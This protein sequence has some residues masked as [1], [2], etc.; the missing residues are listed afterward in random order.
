[1]KFNSERGGFLAF[2]LFLFALFV[3]AVVGAALGFVI[4]FSR[5]LPD[6]NTINEYRPSQTTK[7]FSSDGQ[8]LASLF[9]ENREVVPISKIPTELKLAIMAVEDARFYEHHG[10]D[11]H[12]VMR[13]L[14]RNFKEKRVVEGAS[15]ITQQLARNLFLTRR[16]TL[17]RKLQE[18]M[19]AL[20][21]ER[22]YSKEEI[23]ELYLN[24]IYFGEGAYGVQIAAKTYFGKNPS[25]L[26]LA[27]SALLAGLPRSPIAYS[28]YANFKLARARQ[29]QVLNRMAEAGFIT[30]AEAEKARQETIKL[31]PSRAAQAYRAPYFV[32]YVLHVLEEEFG[33]DLVYRGGLRVHTTVDMRLQAMAD[34]ILKDSVERG[35]RYY[36]ISQGALVSVEPQTGY[37]RAMVGGVDFKQSQFNRAWQAKRQPGSA[38][39]PFVYLAA[40]DNGFAPQTVLVDAPVEFALG[41]GK[42]WRP[43]N[44][45]HRFRGAL[46]LR[47]ALQH[48]VNIIAVKLCDE[49]GPATVVEYARR[50]GALSVDPERDLNLAVALGGLTY[51]VTPLE[52]ASAFGVFG[53]EGMKAKPLG[54]TRV[55]YENGTLLKEFMPERTQVVSRDVALVLTDVLRGVITGGTGRR[56]YI[57]R[58]VAGKTGTTS[59]FKD[60]WFVG[61]TP[62]LSTAVWFGNDN[63]VPTYHVAGGQLPAITWATF[64]REA[65]K[66]VPKKEF[67]KAPKLEAEVEIT[68]RIHEETEQE[69]VLMDVELCKGTG[70]VAT[71]FCPTIITKKLSPDQVPGPCTVHEP[72]KTSP[73]TPETA[74]PEETQ[75]PPSEKKPE[76]SVKPAIPSSQDDTVEV[77]ICRISGKLANEYC[78]EVIVRKFPKGSAPTASCDIHK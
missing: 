9:V 51:G 36:N 56:A 65:L 17:S 40:F 76:V 74:P 69:K 18:M 10:V 19:L 26:T 7:I 46:T 24:Q 25:D 39:K 15:T 77:E 67:A 72:V 32:T 49:L 37:I 12:G 70:K 16:K 20:Q 2:L 54:I 52:M 60:A 63:N 43:K 75:T 57:G 78:P 31:A 30:E 55:T 23:M 41:G 35:K 66:D 5:Q 21:I 33:K 38:F 27:E 14:L 68:Q 48:S 34:K 22:K 1:M 4:S 44:Y 47:R 61:Y 64:M 11:F 73:E 6:V 53:A 3:L 62:D 50:M 42:I 59:D 71:E 28:P 45:D 29:E 13:A 58:D 8:L